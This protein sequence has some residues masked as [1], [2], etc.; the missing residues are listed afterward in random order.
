MSAFSSPMRLMHFRHLVIGEGFCGEEVDGPGLGLL[1]D[2]LEH[3]DVVAQGLAAG[4]GRDK[5]HVFALM[6][7]L[8]GAG[9]V[10]VELM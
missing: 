10:A 5:D 9:L 6:H 2:L 4:R 1:D 8:D 7:Q 3:G